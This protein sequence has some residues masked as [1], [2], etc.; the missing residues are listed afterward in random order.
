MRINEVIDIYSKIRYE[1][2]ISNFKN[3]FLWL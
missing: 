3:D 1:P 2:Y